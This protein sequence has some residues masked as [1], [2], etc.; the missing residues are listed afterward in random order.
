MKTTLTVAATCALLGVTLFLSGCQSD[1]TSE[2][3]SD[4]KMMEEK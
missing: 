1:A 2:K 3:M 4:G